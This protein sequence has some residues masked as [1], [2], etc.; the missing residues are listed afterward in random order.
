M[1]DR[2]PYWKAYY[3][4]N[5]EKKIAQINA[6]RAKRN[7]EHVRADKRRYKQKLKQLSPFVRKLMRD[8]DMPLTKARQLAI[9]LDARQQP[10]PD[11]GGQSLD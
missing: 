10:L 11:K 2:R 5:R 4:R 7:P 3:Q 8:L 6:A 9:E 1:A